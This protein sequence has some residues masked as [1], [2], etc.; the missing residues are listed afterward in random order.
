VRHPFEYLVTRCKELPKEFQMDNGCNLY[1][2]ALAREGGLF[3]G[4]HVTIDELHWRGHK[5]CSKNYSTGETS[6]TPAPR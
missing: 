1:Q 3:K 6:D 5:G 2:Y 4:T